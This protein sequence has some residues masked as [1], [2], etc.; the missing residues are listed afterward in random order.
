MRV[1]YRLAPLL[2]AALL[3][4]V[5]AGASDD[6]VTPA[7][8]RAGKLDLCAG[9]G[10]SPAIEPDVCKRN[11]Y[12]RMSAELD[13]ALQAA[14]A[15]APAN[16]QPLLKRDQGFFGEIFGAAGEAMP[17]S[18]NGE[19]NERLVT[20][21]NQRLA[22]LGRI[23]EGFGRSGVLGTWENTLG[24]LS[25]TPAE[26]GAT[27]LAIDIHVAYGPPDD[28][29]RQWDCQATAL[30]K[31]GANGWLEGTLLSE[32][33]KAADGDAPGAGDGQQVKPPAV[34]L[35]RQGE[36]LRLV[37]AEPT[38]DDWPET[39]H[40]HCRNTPPLTG[41][42]FASGRL[43]P[44]LTPD[45]AATS[46][47]APSFDCAKPFSASDEEICADPELAAKD[48]R[49]NQAWKALQPRLD[50]RRGARSRTISATGSGRR[51]TCTRNSCTPIGTS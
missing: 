16:V 18:D 9:S 10:D 21:V 51:A 17:Q 22:A 2:F 38:V 27:R 43:D 24:K 48:V 34:K 13:R 46:F 39:S 4:P 33:T 14:L 6:P 32:Q 40:P 11:G 45:T 42:Y 23:A 3:V 49:L 29:E 8:S 50:G 35:R 7:F 28:E 44:A 12:D 1:R 20:I 36:T 37:V 26:G 25:V 47:V 15:K 5:A 31:P 41:T 30:L 19:A